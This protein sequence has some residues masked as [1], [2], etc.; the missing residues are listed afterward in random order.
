M[1]AHLLDGGRAGPVEVE[2][3]VG[4]VGRPAGVGEEGPQGVVAGVDP[5]DGAGEAVGG[6]GVDGRLEQPRAVALR[7]A[8]RGRG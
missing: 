8:P 1:E 3:A 2:L 4:R 6:E 7:R 5:G